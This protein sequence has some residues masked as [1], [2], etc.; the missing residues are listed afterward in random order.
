M[1]KK[2]SDDKPVVKAAAPKKQ[3]PA[4]GKEVP[5]GPVVKFGPQPTKPK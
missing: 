2:P 5:G 4:P 1:P 3:K